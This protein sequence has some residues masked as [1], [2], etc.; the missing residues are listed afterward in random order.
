MSTKHEQQVSTPAAAHTPQP[1]L[2]PPKR[3]LGALG[4]LRKNLFSSPLNTLLTV[5]AIAII[6]LVVPPLVDWA[7]IH[8]DWAG[9]S[10]EACTSVGACWTFVSARFGQFIFGFYPM[11]Q[12]WRVVFTFAMFVVLILSLHSRR[13][14]GRAWIA[15][16][17]LVIA[18]LIAFFLLRGGVFG[19]PV[20]R[21]SQ[22]GG[23]T[24]TLILAAVGMVTALP[25]GILLALGRRSNMPV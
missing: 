3:Q 7:F 1:D 20:V 11:E 6:Y 22:W 15:L 25:M 9:H 5:L 4:W 17:T 12:Q 13:V 8:A 2:P 10:K 19:L 18:P 21:T 24:L 14:P 23:L 16:F